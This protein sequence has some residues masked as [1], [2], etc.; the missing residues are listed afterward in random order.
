MVLKIDI[1][2]AFDTL[3]FELLD[4]SNLQFSILYKVYFLDSCHLYF[5]RIL[6]NA[7]AGYLSINTGV[8]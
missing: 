1:R 4:G 6:V 7:L 2:K 3:N 8:H 5:D